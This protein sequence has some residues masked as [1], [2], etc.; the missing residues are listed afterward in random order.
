MDYIEFLEAQIL[1]DGVNPKL[2]KA[3]SDARFQKAVYTGLNQDYILEQY[4]VLESEPQKAQRKRITTTRTKHTIRQAE[5]VISQLEV[6]DKPSINVINESEN[7]AED[8]MSFIIK[9]NIND[10]AFD[11]VS[12]YNMT[13]ANAFVTCGENEFE[14]IEYKVIGVENLY[15]Y[16]IV[17]K[18]LKLVI[19]QLPR[20]LESGLTVNDYKMYTKDSVVSYVNIQGTEIEGKQTVT[21]EGNTFVVDKIDTQMMYA[22]RLGYIDDMSNNQETC[23]SILDAASELL[24]SLIWQGSELDV[25][26]GTQG[27]VKQFAY[28]NRCQYRIKTD[29]GVSA[30]VGGV[31]N[32]HGTPSGGICPKCSNGL[33]IHTSSQDIVHFP[34][35]TGDAPL[36]DLSKLTHTVFVPT[37]IL[38]YKRAYLREI[39]DDIIKT[40]F[41]SSMVTKDDHNVTATEKKIDLQGIYATLNQ[42][43]KQVSKCFI[44]MVRCASYIHHNKDS[45]VIHGYTLNLTLED[46]FSLSEK[47][48]ALLDSN[49]PNI[50]LKAIDMAMIQKQMM[51]SP[52]YIARYGIWESFRPFSGKPPMEIQQILATIPNT[53]RDKI[54]YNFFDQIKATIEREQEDIFYK[55]DSNGQLKIIDS[56][57]EKIRVQLN[58]ELSSAERVDLKDL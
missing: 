42:I 32:I 33:Q 15:D 40:F 29:E 54:L 7:I 41:N 19:F 5:N 36:P 9:E 16:R 53:Y 23:V 26:D 56:E 34:F 48:K 58:S 55:A 8:L 24:R 25:I 4:R 45:D 44:W 52:V 11:F 3:I 30:C 46:V 31:M 49:A 35:P 39:K 13:D 10:L 38:D 2:T 12:Y 50:L 14:E 20:K 27:V 47:R 43:G 28:A 37:H 51:G 21:I 1:R 57:I 18:Q 22:F 17:N 6:M